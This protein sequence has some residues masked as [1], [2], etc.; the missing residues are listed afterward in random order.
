MKK[1]L[2]WLK[3]QV[4]E[5]ETKIKNLLDGATTHRTRISLNGSLATLK[6]FRGYINQLDEP[7]SDYAYQKGFREGERQTAEYFESVSEEPSYAQVQ[8]YLS[9]HGIKIADKEPETVAG[10]VT[11]F[12]KSYERLKEVMSMEVEELEE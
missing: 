5:T 6:D 2:D 9:E 12:W 8:K 3:N 1:D 7:D 11:T 10:V 4:D